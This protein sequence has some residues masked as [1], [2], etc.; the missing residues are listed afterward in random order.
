M[1]K[2]KLEI[3]WAFTFEKEGNRTFQLTQTGMIDKVL[4]A[5]GLE[6]CNMVGDSRVQHTSGFGLL[7]R[8]VHGGLGIFLHVDVFGR[9]HAT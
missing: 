2:A 5:E 3:Y 6:E 4:N 1:T 7:W 9:Q 8:I